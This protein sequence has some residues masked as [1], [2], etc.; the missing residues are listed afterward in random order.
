MPFD[1]PSRRDPDISKGLVPNPRFVE[2][3]SLSSR[4]PW[5]SRCLPT[6]RLILIG[7]QR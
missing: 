2:D 3:M 7:L 4:S 6:H 1:Q 5:F